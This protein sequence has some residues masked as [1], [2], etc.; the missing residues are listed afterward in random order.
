[1]GTIDLY[2]VSTASTLTQDERFFNEH[3]TYSNVPVPAFKFKLR[4]YRLL[5]YL[6]WW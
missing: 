4:L 2:V 6:S 5:A 3:E 1:M